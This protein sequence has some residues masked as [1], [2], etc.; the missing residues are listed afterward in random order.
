MNEAGVRGVWQVQSHEL[1]IWDWT[2]ALEKSE[3]IC[4]SRVAT[5]DPN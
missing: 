3:A 4:P 5:L 1:S 2:T